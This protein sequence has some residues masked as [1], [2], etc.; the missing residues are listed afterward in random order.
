M[1]DDNLYYSNSKGKFIKIAEM[2]DQ[3]VRYAFIKMN[4]EIPSGFRK[5]MEE[6]LELLRDDMCERID[7]IQ[8]D[9]REKTNK[10]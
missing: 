5:D 1:S 8:E 3:H 4:K 2:P 9:I 10:D 6:Q 7:K